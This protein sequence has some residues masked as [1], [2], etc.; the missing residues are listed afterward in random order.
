MLSISEMFSNNFQIKMCINDSGNKPFEKSISGVYL[1]DRSICVCLRA[2][3][4]CICFKAFALNRQHVHNKGRKSCK[5]ITNRGQICIW[6]EHTIVCLFVRS[7]TVA[8]CRVHKVKILCC[9]F[10]AICLK[11]EHKWHVFIPKFVRIK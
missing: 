8:S 2:T 3:V 10:R 1:I 7:L 5:I 9:I 4:L 6:E 11:R